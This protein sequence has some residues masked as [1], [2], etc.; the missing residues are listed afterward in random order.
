MKRNSFVWLIV[1]SFSVLL[2][3]AGCSAKTEHADADLS[4]DMAER[5]ARMRHRAKSLVGKP[6]PDNPVHTLTAGT[7]RLSRFWQEKPALIMTGSLTCPVARGDI[8]ELEK[9][10]ERF[11]D[12]INVVMLYTIEAHP[13]TDE[14]PYRPGEEWQV[15][16]NEEQGILCRQP[17]SLDERIALARRFNH[18]F[19]PKSTIVVDRM[20]N[21]GWKDMG[22]MPCMAVLVDEGGIVN[23][24]Q[25]WFDAEAMADY[26]Q[27]ILEQ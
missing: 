15:D 23:T 13:E 16:D 5:H 4:E 20:D 25:T 10:R 26:I 22:R 6:A 12:R 7:T 11:G 8:S 27:T 9:L 3:I 24:T 21:A 14:S 17:T 18:M 2:A 1:T 19:Q